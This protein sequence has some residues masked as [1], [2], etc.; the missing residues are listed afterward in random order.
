MAVQLF[1]RFLTDRGEVDEFHVREA[2]MLMEAENATLGERA[3]ARAFMQERDVVRVITE[4]RT[5]D[6]SFGELA[7]EMGLLG[8]EQLAVLLRHPHSQPLRFG[9]A[10]V[11]LGY[12]E[13]D[14]LGVLLDAFKAAESEYRTDPI[15]LPDALANHRATR[16][17]L[18]LFPRFTM[19]MARIHARVAVPRVFD[20]IPEFAEL[21]VSIPIRGVC[22]LAVS[23]LADVEFAQPLAIATRGLEQASLEPELQRD[24]VGAF[25]NLL[26]GNVVTLLAQDGHRL[27]LGTPDYE[28]EPGAGWIADLAVD[29]GHAALVLS[30]F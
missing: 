22:G 29:R 16:H 18:E 24:A 30:P 20:G 27:E 17:V 2:L 23:L 19:R 28:V 5:R 10:L 13:P 8:S 21:R 3:I 15:D 14:R 11:R 1:G 12:L 7:A 26:L 6:A 25:L 4:Q 9:E